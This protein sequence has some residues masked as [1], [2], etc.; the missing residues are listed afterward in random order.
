MLMLITPA[1]GGGAS[2][3]FYSS[4]EEMMHAMDW[5]NEPQFMP[6]RWLTLQEARQDANYWDERDAFLAEI[7]PLRLVPKE[8]VITHEIAVGS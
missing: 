6:K 5:D 1:D 7:K 2:I 3:G 4:M 8:T